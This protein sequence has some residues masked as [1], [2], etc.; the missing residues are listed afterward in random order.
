M[1]YQLIKDHYP[2]YRF[3]KATAKKCKGDIFFIHGYAVNSDYHDYFGDLVTDY[4]YYAIE[5]AG[6]G[7]TPLND[8]KQLNPYSYALEVVKLIKELNLKDIILMG[9]S[10]G[11]GIAVMVS[12]MIPELIKKMIIV[13]PMNSKGTMSIKGA[14]DFLFNFQPKNEKQIDKFYNI[15]MYDYY[16]DK[17]QVTDKEK[18]QVMKNQ[19]DYK[20]NF[21]ILKR[22]MA[23]AS[24][25]RRLK[26]AEKDIE[27]PTLLIVGKGDGCINAKSTI[28]NFT[29]KNKDIQVHTFEKSG[30]I[31]FLEETQSYYDVIMN[32]I[33]G[34]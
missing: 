34:K 21:N 28:K 18:Q 5:H 2:Y 10:M 15:I 26:K 23:S 25:M 7:I 30:H 13:T 31:P 24:N 6:H 9:H 1:K 4:N 12:H 22:K 17:S 27:V 33:E 8:K 3:K 11:G 16:R 19:R 14:I 20:K 32:F 29:K